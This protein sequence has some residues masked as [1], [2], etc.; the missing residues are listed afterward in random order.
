MRGRRS[1][2][3]T[4]A[5]VE[6]VAGPSSGAA[7]EVTGRQHHSGNRPGRGQCAGTCEGCDLFALASLLAE[8]LGQEHPRR[9]IILVHAEYPSCT[10][11]GHVGGAPREVGA[12]RSQLLRSVRA[13]PRRQCECDEQ[14]AEEDRND[15]ADDGPQ[16]AARR[17]EP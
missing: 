6:P 14:D 7:R 11:L 13:P 15:E 2:A 17:S 3:A 16:A 12:R 10:D 5:A 8:R 9:G 4:E 1:V